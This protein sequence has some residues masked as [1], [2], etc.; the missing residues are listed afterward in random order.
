MLGDI[1]ILYILNTSISWGLFLIIW[2]VQIIIYPGLSRIPSKG[3][4]N[5]HRWYV[6]RISAIVLPMMICEV[7]ITI[8]WLMLDH[9]SFYSSASA[10]LVVIIWLSTFVLQLPIH[11]HL[12]FGKDDLLIKRLVATNWIL[13]IAWS[14]KAVAV[15]LAAVK[16]S[17]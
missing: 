5:Y 16:N 1:S 11:K 14:M 17:L 4:V 7:I 9:Y 8:R 13:A 12:Q 2:L 15:T 10:L 6:K 3:F